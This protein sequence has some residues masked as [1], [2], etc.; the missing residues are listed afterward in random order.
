MFPFHQRDVMRGDGS[1]EFL[2]ILYLLKM[3]GSK[4]KAVVKMGVQGHFWL[5]EHLLCYQ[6]FPLFLWKCILI[7][8]LGWT[9]Q[10][11]LRWSWWNLDH[12]RMIA[13]SF[14]IIWQWLISSCSVSALHHRLGY[15]VWS[16]E[17]CKVGP[18]SWMREYQEILG[19]DSEVKKKILGKSFLHCC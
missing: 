3:H 11:D 18:G 4:C 12:S 19:L 14:S 2:H 10:V 6:S 15:H 8:A 1:F 16:P 5:L 17:I 7:L 13:M 9:K